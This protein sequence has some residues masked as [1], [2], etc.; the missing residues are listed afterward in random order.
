MK[1]LKR[2]LF[3]LVTV[4]LAVC[5]VAS[6]GAE[7][8]KFTDT[9]T[10]WAWTEGYIP[11]LVEKNV[12][13]GYRKSDGTYFFKPDGEVTRAE[14]IKML[15][16][17]FGLTATTAVNYTDVKDTDWFTVYFEKA[18]AQ[19][20]LLNYGTKCD[21]N[22]KINREEAISLLVRYLNLDGE[23]KAS[24][25][26][27][28]DYNEITEK[29][30]DYVLEAI[31]AD[32]I[33]GYEQSNGSFKFKPANTLTRAEALTILYRAAGCIY[34]KTSFVRDAGAAATNN[35]VTKGGITIQGQTLKGRTIVSEGASSD[36]VTFSNCTIDGTLYVRGNAK[37]YFDKCTVK[38]VVIDGDGGISLLTN[39]KI[40]NVTLN[41]KAVVSVSSGTSVGTLDVGGHAT[42]SSVIG[43]GTIGKILV[44][45]A[46]FVSS[47]MPADYEIFN[48]HTATF[49]GQKFTDAGDEASIFKVAP[50]ATVDNNDFYL[51]FTATKDGTLYYYYTTEDKVPDA[52]EFDAEYLKAIYNGRIS[53]KADTPA[54][55]KTYS[56][57]ELAKYNYAVVMFQS[58]TT[59]YTPVLVSNSAS[60]STGFSTNPTFNEATSSV[61]FKVSTNGTVYMYYTNSG[62]AVSQT[63][64]IAN[65]DKCD[66][67]LKTSVSATTK[68]AQS[69]VLNSANTKNYSYV[70]LMLKSAGGAYYN[71]VVVA[72]ADDGFAVLPEVKTSGIISYKTDVTGTMYYYYSKTA[73]VPSS[74]D[75]SKVYNSA[76]YKGNAN[77]TKDTAATL[78]YKAS[79]ASAYPYLVVCLK[80]AD[81]AYK[82]PVC[83][84]LGYESGFIVVPKLVD[85]STIAFTAESAGTLQFYYTENSEAPSCEMFAAVYNTMPASLKGSL[86]FYTKQY[87]GAI[88]IPDTVSEKMYVVIMM[89]D[90]DKNAFAPIVLSLKY[91]PEDLLTGFAYD[92]YLKDGEVYIKTATTTT[93]RYYYST[94]AAEVTSEAFYTNYSRAEFKGELSA[95]KDSLTKLTVNRTAALAYR[96]IVLAT[97]NGTYYSEPVVISSTLETGK[98]EGTTG[99]TWTISDGI[100]KVLPTYTG[101]LY[102]YATDD[103][104]DASSTTFDK[105]KAASMS[106]ASAKAVAINNLES[107]KYVILCLEV[108][109]YLL[110]KV[111]IDTTTGKV[112]TEEKY[113]DGSSSTKSMFMANNDAEARKLSIMSSV[114][115]R[116]YFTLVGDNEVIAFNGNTAKGNVAA[117]NVV[118]GEP[119][120]FDYKDAYTAAQNDKTHEHV[121]LYI[122]IFDF[123][124][125]ITY[126]SEAITLK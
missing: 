114:D 32:L 27:F 11:Y 1:K 83:V 66:A 110:D 44:R 42:N 70:V 58:G 18:E 93:V 19:G 73:E 100:V 99:F 34:K 98:P 74:A 69:I 7:T 125:N 94:S 30:R 91:R 37:V 78:S 36:I 17:T 65:Y 124:K 41:K 51:S 33:E 62:D 52:S 22:G 105:T 85:E 112:Y 116:M 77:V 97:W 121:Y 43:E 21:P 24:A 117:R 56:K 87:Q 109:D 10:H 28:T 5:T 9:D 6:V 8:I 26:T 111:A 92:P 40:D 126:K 86:T 46:G 81:G 113:D 104:A 55:A 79:Y 120:E 88:K 101:T 68:A 47:I 38:N 80:T 115:A 2:I 49:A 39:T 82:L 35:V 90:A 31:S 75:F 57:A 95:S 50:F 118:T 119:F 103:K 61:G 64:F 96:S 20:Y 54:S 102:Y 15:D 63:Q 45:S 84:D 107:K 29:Y 14:F 48:G 23:Q 89:T 12:L 53:A 122:Q 60:T 25:S 13:N 4:I 123:T 3:V 72:I 108:N 76:S 106:V 59:G 16:E 67:A 71:P